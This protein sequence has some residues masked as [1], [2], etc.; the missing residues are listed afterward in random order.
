MFRMILAF[1]GV[2]VAPL[3]IGGPDY[4]KAF[5]PPADGMTRHVLKLPGQNNE[6]D[7][8]IEL[9]VGKTMKVDAKNRRFF[10]GK[11]KAETIKGWGFARYVLEKLGPMAGTLMAPE[12]GAPKVEKFVSLG[13]EPYLIRYNSKLPLVVYVPKGVEVRYR[14]W[15]ANPVSEPIEEG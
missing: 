8:R 12:P 14:L 6:A 9:I 4:M 3:A 13:G 15:R 5:P 11:I 2:A 10:S 7:L 1:F